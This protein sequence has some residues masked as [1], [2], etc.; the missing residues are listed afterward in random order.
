MLQI[1][2][3]CI[4][5]LLLHTVN[6]LS[7]DLKYTI[8]S[9]ETASSLQL[10]ANSPH[11]N[12]FELNANA[13]DKFSV[14]L[15][16][17]KRKLETSEMSLDQ[18]YETLIV[19]F[20]ADS[21]IWMLVKF[22]EDVN[23]Q[24]LLSTDNGRN[25]DIYHMFENDLDDVQIQN[26]FVSSYDRSFVIFTDVK[27]GVLFVV[28]D[29]GRSMA[30]ID[31]KP[32]VFYFT[33]DSSVI[34]ALDREN[35]QLWL[36]TNTGRTWKS[37]GNNIVQFS[38][39][40]TR[41]TNSIEHIYYLESKTTN[42]TELIRFDL[43]NYL[44]DVVN[45]DVASLRHVIA[46]D[47][48][49]FVATNDRVFIMKTSG[50]KGLT[51]EISRNS[52]EFQEAEFELDATFSKVLDL[53]VTLATDQEIF[54]IVTYKLNNNLQSDLFRS[55]KSSNFMQ[56]K[57]SL[58]GIINRCS[59][60]ATIPLNRPHVLDMN[61]NSCIEMRVLKLGHTY[62]ANARN[63]LD[64]VVTFVK[65]SVSSEWTPIEFEKD[66]HKKNEAIDLNDNFLLLHLES[67]GTSVEDLPDVIFAKGKE[68]GF[69][70]SS[71]EG[72]EWE[73]L[74]FG[75]SRTSEYI[76][77][78]GESEVVAVDVNQPTN[79]L[80]YS[81]D[82][83]NNWNEFYFSDTLVM[84]KKLLGTNL[85]NKPTFFMVCTGAEN[86]K[87]IKRFEFVPQTRYDDEDQTSY[88]D[89][90][91]EPIPNPYDPSLTSTTK[92]QPSTTTIQPSSTSTPLPS[93]TTIQTSSSTIQPSSTST[94]L[95]ST[96]TIQTSSSTIQPSSTSTPL[97]STTTIQTSTSSTSL[98]SIKTNTAFPL[99]SYH[100]R[101][102]MI[103]LAKLIAPMLAF[104]MVILILA[105]LWTRNRKRINA[106]WTAMYNKTMQNASFNQVSSSLRRERDNILK[107]PIVNLDDR[108][109]L[110]DN[111][112]SS[113]QL[114]A[115][116]DV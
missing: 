79:V 29:K 89:D 15:M 36:T 20:G 13:E 104:V 62:L 37:I 46:N 22:N 63:A 6:S 50:E 12:T 44:D 87:S 35:S 18:D 101:M 92:I 64:K 30:E 74:K 52:G 86:Q 28:S 40:I 27:N 77:L 107:K 4:S 1:N 39:S 108:V 85:E 19:Q 105:I 31:F 21:I 78:N 16:H 91:E 23:N 2:L 115:Y 88:D 83:G 42:A 96:T 5:L 95:P 73:S 43:K 34:L 84:V 24:V 17:H 49:D 38:D 57:Q 51:L 66:I 47:V 81:Y 68:S 98:P 32:E 75:P 82:L 76:Y 113:D 48:T 60:N 10:L 112:D 67:E 58:Q 80:L 106:Y 69:Y 14:D 59:D 56:F 114:P 70:V 116:S 3:L 109:F 110:I 55:D 9:T 71:D 11:F 26:I 94:P 93:T 103:Q 61:Q 45:E 111:D 54:V 25:Y 72:S 90:N 7:T 65:R 99:L 33:K 53:Q 102:R 97:P 100:D 41:D 8:N